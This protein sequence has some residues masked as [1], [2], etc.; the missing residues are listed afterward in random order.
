MDITGKNVKQ[1]LDMIMAEE[2][3]PTVTQPSVSVTCNQMKAYEVGTSVTPRYTVI[4]NPGSYQ[5][6][7]GYKDKN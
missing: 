4:L 5:Y 7:E 2:K 3:N 1:V 6:G